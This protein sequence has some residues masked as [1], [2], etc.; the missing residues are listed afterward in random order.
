MNSSSFFPI[1][2]E[3][4]L[5]KKSLKFS[6]YPKSLITWLQDKMDSTISIPIRFSILKVVYRYIYI[7]SHQFGLFKNLPWETKF[8]ILHSLFL[9]LHPTLRIKY[10]EKVYAGMPTSCFRLLAKQRCQEC[11]VEAKWMNVRYLAKL[12]TYSFLLEVG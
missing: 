5:V 8:V 10:V 6:I 3:T 11:H 12:P 2:P 9:F 1:P 7:I 4:G